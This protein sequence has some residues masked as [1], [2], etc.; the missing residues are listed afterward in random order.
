M[1]QFQLRLHDQQRHFDITRQG[2][3]LHISAEDITA[4]VHILHQN[5][6]E[7][8]IE[9][10]DASGTRQRIRLAGTRNGDRRQVWIDGRYLTVERVRQ[11]SSGIGADQGSLVASIPAVVS[12]ILV[13]P[14]DVV[15]AGDKLILLE[16]MKMVIPIQA[17]YPGRVT[18]ILCAAGSSVPAGI[19]LVELEAL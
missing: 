4:D 11:R 1:P 15:K 3:R 5:G 12:Q 9:Y 18:R 17:P 2:D 16:S 7:F 8:L 19:P 13:E 14:G 10:L 6:R